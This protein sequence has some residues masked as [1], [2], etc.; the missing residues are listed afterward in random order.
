MLANEAGMSIIQATMMSASV[1]E[2]GQYIRSW[3][4]AGGRCVHHYL[5]NV[6][7]NLRYLLFSTSLVPYFRGQVPTA[8]GSLY[9][10]D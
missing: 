1:L 9:L 6:F 5:A 10:M 2:A 3:Y 4:H 7:M 8:A